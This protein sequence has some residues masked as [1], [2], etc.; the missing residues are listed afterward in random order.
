MACR[1]LESSWARAAF[2]SCFA[3]RGGV[4]STLPGATAPTGLALDSLQ[5]QNLLQEYVKLRKQLRET[6]LL[7]GRMDG[8]RSAKDELL[9]T[10][11]DS[12]YAEV[13]TVL[14][15]SYAID[16]DLQNA[17]QAVGSLAAQHPETADVLADYGYS[18]PTFTPAE[19]CPIS[20]F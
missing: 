3:A 1:V 12:L 18:N 14:W 8:A 10:Q 5:F 20:L 16:G 4:G 13:V 7:L 6:Q 17:C 9:S 2:S 19:V 15:D 11:P